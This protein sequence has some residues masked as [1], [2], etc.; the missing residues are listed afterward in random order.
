MEFNFGG[1][2]KNK[3]KSTKNWDDRSKKA[4]L[5]K[6]DA[7]IQEA[8]DREG[9]QE[10]RDATFDKAQFMKDEIKDYIEAEKIYRECY[11][12]SG[13]PSRKMEVLFE[14]LLMNL[15]KFDMEAV[16][17]DVDTCIKHVTDG[18]DW[19]KKNK[20]KVFHGVYCMLIRDFKQAADLLLSC[21]ASFTCVELMD[22]TQ[23]VFYAVVMG[24]MTQDRKTIKKQIIHSSD[25]LSVIRDVPALK[26]F[27]ESFYNCEYQSFFAAFVDILDQISNDQY[28]KEHV[29]YYGK[30]MRLVAYRQYLES[31]K[32][33]TIENMAKAFG[34]T[35][36]F[37]DGELSNFI[38]NGKINCKI[39]KVTGV[40][41]SNRPN[42]K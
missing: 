16:K 1:E 17:K 14:I 10:I 31:F 27:V 40:I 32:S 30:Q 28:L 18:A 24:M 7:K 21:V 35:V 11:E 37:L 5:A 29:S 2:I 22:Y 8:K 15:E 9:D 4:E 42:R 19:D 13:G 25:V 38:Y 36:P 12:L 41:E 23:F 33:V 39:D 6:F 20:F 34:V 26:Q 3:K